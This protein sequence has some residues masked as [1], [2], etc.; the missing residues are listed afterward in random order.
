MP[1]LRP[2]AGALKFGFYWAIVAFLLGLL[3]T[4]LVVYSSGR[5][6][7]NPWFFAINGG[8][9]GLVSGMLVWHVLMGRRSSLMRAAISG[10]LTGQLTV[11]LS[12]LMLALAYADPASGGGSH[13]LAS[14][15]TALSMSLMGWVTGYGVFP[16][17][18]AMGLAIALYHWRLMAK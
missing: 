12:L 18:L 13:L 1:I 6:S 5:A 9:W 16:P 17:L 14:V 3:A 11:S 10:L 2:A 15:G 4:G 7:A 8:L